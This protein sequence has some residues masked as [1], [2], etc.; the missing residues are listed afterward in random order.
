M[1]KSLWRASAAGFVYLQDMRA[2]V[3][4]AISG[5]EIDMILL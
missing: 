1:Q 4:G 3:L 2:A 5:L